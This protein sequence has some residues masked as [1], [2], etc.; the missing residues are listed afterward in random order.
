MVFSENLTQ[1]LV[2]AINQIRDLLEALK[3]ER[4]R[5]EDLIVKLED[6][7]N[8]IA[9]LMR[10]NQELRDSIIQMESIPG[11]GADQAGPL[12]TR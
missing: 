3:R 10:E 7:E 6:R 2:V 11:P 9:T 12:R 4:E 8:V 5:N 1:Q